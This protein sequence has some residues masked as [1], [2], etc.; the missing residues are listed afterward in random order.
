MRKVV[1]LIRCYLCCWWK[2]TAISRLFPKYRYDGQKFCQKFSSAKQVSV[3]L[4]QAYTLSG[5]DIYKKITRHSEGNSYWNCS[6]TP[7]WTAEQFTCYCYYVYRKVAWFCCKTRISI[8][9]DKWKFI[10][11]Y[12]QDVYIFFV[13]WFTA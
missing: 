1:T 13:V 2:I 5:D 12:M 8:R 9:K 10:Y 3:A 4:S 6:E 11:V 7:Y